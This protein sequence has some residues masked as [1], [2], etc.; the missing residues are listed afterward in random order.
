MC[1]H[2]HA[3]TQTHKLLIKP[4][5]A[6]RK[7]VTCYFTLHAKE[8]LG[9]TFQKMPFKYLTYIFLLLAGALRFNMVYVA[10]HI[11]T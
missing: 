5:I 1:T 4:L 9:R 11:M 10:I 8:K 7:G 2:V 6:V 3:N